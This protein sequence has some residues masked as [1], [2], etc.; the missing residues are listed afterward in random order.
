MFQNV[1]EN[2]QSHK[3]EW[4]QDEDKLQEKPKSEKLRAEP[5][6]EGMCGLT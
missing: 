5:V 6:W 2:P 3:T 1:F 4:T